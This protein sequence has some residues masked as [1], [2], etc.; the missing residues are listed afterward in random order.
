MRDL[1]KLKQAHTN[2]SEIQNQLDQKLYPELSQKLGEAQKLTER[3]IKILEANHPL[4]I[5]KNIF[6]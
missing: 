4:N 2:I 3:H 6:K 5:L 1:V